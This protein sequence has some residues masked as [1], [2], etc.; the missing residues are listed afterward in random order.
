MKQ[1]GILNQPLFKNYVNRLLLST[2][3]SLENTE[4]LIKQFLENNLLDI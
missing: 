3:N 4:Q 1:P 2:D